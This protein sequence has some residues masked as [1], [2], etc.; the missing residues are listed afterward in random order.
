MVSPEDWEAI[1]RYF[2][3]EAPDTILVEAPAPTTA[4]TQF[5]VEAITLPAS[6]RFPM[7]SLLQVDTAQ[8]NLHQQPIKLVASMELFVSGN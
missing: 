3:R 4:L 8:K 2:E 5:K 7:L 1:V 6:N